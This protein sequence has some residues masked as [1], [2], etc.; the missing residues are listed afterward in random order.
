VMLA[1]HVMHVEPR[2]RNNAFGIV[3][4]GWLRQMR[5]VASVYHERRLL[6]QRPYPSYRLLQRALGIG[7]GRL[8]KTHVAVADLQEGEAFTLLRQ[9]LIDDAER[10][11]H[12]AGDGP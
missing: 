3:E 11:R 9:R 1:R 12:S 8:V 7:V 6:G 10:S 5:D 2:L 4:F